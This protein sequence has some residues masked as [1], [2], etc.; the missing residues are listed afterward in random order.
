[1]SIASQL[2]LISELTLVVSL[3]EEKYALFLKAHIIN[4]AVFI[5]LSTHYCL[6][7]WNDT[8]VL[9]QSYLYCIQ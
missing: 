3:S 2:P 9:T 6:E 5:L 7:A 4:S 8:S 1:M